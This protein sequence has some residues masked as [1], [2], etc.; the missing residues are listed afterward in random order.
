MPHPLEDEYNLTAGE[1]LDMINGRFR[2]KVALSG[3]V[4]EV[5]C[6]KRLAA[7]RESGIISL[8]EHHDIDD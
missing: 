7:L 1:L 5:Q 3:A 8:Y 2:L 6:E 4:A